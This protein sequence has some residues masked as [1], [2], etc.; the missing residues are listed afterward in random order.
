MIV[1][2][3][4]QNLD[5]NDELA[6]SKRLLDEK[7]FEAGRLREEAVAKGDQNNDARAQLQDLE[8]EIESVKVQR[9]EMWRELTRLKEM[10]EARTSEAAQQSD[11]LKSLDFELARTQARIED[12]QKLLDCRSADLRNK[13]LA[14]EDTERELGRV[15]DENARLGSENAALRRDNERVAAE[16]YDLRKEVDFQEGRNADVSVQIRD[17]EMRLKEREDTLFAVRRDVE[18]LRVT[19]QQNRNDNGDLLAEREALEKHAGCLQGQNADLA[20]ELERFVQTDEV[21]RGQLDRRGRVYGLQNK[22]QDELRQ[23]YYR[24]DQA[25]SRSPAKR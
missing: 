25:R 19:S 7:Y 24:V 22:N 4:K 16:N 1:Y 10:N 9:A 23:S 12:T 5:L 13:Q 2:R 20:G 15:R 8:R 6:R 3:T 11:K 21:L 14:L 17:S 18:S